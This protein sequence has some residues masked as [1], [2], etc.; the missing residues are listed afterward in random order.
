MACSL[1][2]ISGN[3]LPAT[4]LLERT[5]YRNPGLVLHTLRVNYRMSYKIRNQ[6]DRLR[7]LYLRDGTAF[8]FNDRFR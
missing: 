4:R 6:A 3:D 2:A 5:W 7:P 8:V 1:P